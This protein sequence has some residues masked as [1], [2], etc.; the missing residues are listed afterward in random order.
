MRT[1]L[2]VLLFLVLPM[3]D[4]APPRHDKHANE[5]NSY[6]MAGPPLPDQQ[7]RG[8]YQCFCKMTCSEATPESP[9]HR[10]EDATCEHFCTS[11]RCLCHGDQS[12]D[13]MLMEP[14]K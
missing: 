8:A 1:I 2:A 6:C 7:A 13:S 9:S 12:C 10:I 5:P 4:P 14:P 3:Q 11:S